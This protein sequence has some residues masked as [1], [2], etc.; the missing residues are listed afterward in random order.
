MLLIGVWIASFVYLILSNRNNP[1]L[2]TLCKIS[3]K[4]S[5]FLYQEL[6]SEYQVEIEF[7]KI[8]S[9]E[10]KLFRNIDYVIISIKNN[11]E[12]TCINLDNQDEFVNL[13]RI[14]ANL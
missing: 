11:F 5:S 9:I 6:D 7:N 10:T 2:N 14:Q 13:A 3:L 1:D 4:E 8:I 12:L